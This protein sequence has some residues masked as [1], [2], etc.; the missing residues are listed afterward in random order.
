MK[1][2][3]ILIAIASAALLAGCEH[4]HIGEGNNEDTRRD[5]SLERQIGH[6]NCRPGTPHDAAAPTDWMCGNTPQSER[7]EARH[8]VEEDG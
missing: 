3:P 6:N 5:A 4:I 1:T 8:R 7:P 2:S